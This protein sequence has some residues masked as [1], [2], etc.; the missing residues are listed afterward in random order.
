[1]RHG[2][3]L[4]AFLVLLPQHSKYFD[5]RLKSQS[6]STLP[7]AEAADA[8]TRL[9]RSPLVFI[10]SRIIIINKM[11]TANASARIK[12]YPILRANI[13]IPKDL[14]RHAQA[15]LMQSL[16]SA[17]ALD[18]PP[19]LADLATRNFIRAQLRL[20]LLP[21]RDSDDKFFLDVSLCLLLLLLDIV[22]LDV[23]DVLCERAFRRRSGRGGRRR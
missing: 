9:E 1:M 18:I 8:D 19:I 4:R 21:L 14:L 10:P 15:F 23:R 3:S 12:T 6:I 2:H 16:R 22:G 17:L 13:P 20:G 11:E 5:G 7:A